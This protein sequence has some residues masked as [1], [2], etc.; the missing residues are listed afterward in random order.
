[1]SKMTA[2]SGVSQPLLLCRYAASFCSL[3]IEQTERQPSAGPMQKMQQRFS[4]VSSACSA[5]D[6]CANTEK[7]DC[8]TAIE[9]DTAASLISCSGHGTEN[10]TEDRLGTCMDLT[11]WT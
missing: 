8:Q 10:Y 6:R 11:R 3:G 7:P 2:D 9:F 5:C 1:M 4:P